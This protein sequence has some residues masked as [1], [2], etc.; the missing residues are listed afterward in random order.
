M[1]TLAILI[2]TGC[3]L[4]GAT[5]QSADYPTR[6]IRL[7]V[8]YAAGGAS[9]IPA[10]ILAKKMSESLGQNILIENIAGA[11]TIGAGNV[12][13]AEPDGYTL[14]FGYATQFTIAPPLYPNLNYDPIK[15]FAPI[16]SVM[17][18]HFLMTAHSSVP[19]NTLP[20]LVTHAKANPGKV[21]FASP[22]VG[23]ST[24]LIGELFKLT[25]G[26]DIVHVPYRGGGPAITDLV[27]GRID[28]YRDAPAGLLPWVEKG[29][30][31]PLAVTSAQRLS[32]SAKR[33]HGA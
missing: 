24:H 18:F 30:I 10:R 11:G 32:Q 19:V 4:L 25:Q 15:S 14:L 17:R 29:N 5:A 22:G 27:A 9:D 26:I 3:T 2:A 8:P 21:T 33:P 31:K 12:A 16:G 20:E 28:I 13:R 23:T 7:I 1:R 6:P